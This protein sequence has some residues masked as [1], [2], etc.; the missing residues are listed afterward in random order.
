MTSGYRTGR[1]SFFALAL[2]VAGAIL[3]IDNLGILPRENVR[4]YWPLAFVVAGLG[5]VAN[6]VCTSSLVWAG[7]LS[8][9]GVALILGNLGIIR[10]DASVFWP[11]LLI[12]LG[13][14]SLL[15]RTTF[16]RHWSG[17][18]GGWYRDGRRGPWDCNPGSPAQGRP[19]SSSTQSA[20]A[21]SAGTNEGS[22]PDAESANPWGAPQAWWGKHDWRRWKREERRRRFRDFVEHGY[23]KSAQMGGWL[24]EVAVLFSTRRVFAGRDVSGGKIASV[25]GSIELDFTD[26]NIPLRTRAD[27]TVVR[28]ADIDAD[29]V[30]GS[31]DLRVPPHWRV[32]NRGVGVFGSYENK[33]LPPR[34]EV[35]A[36][37]PTLF[38]HGGAVFGSVE[39]R[40]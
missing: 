39:I 25:F 36:E 11:I 32:I 26:A 23:S 18:N 2:I 21:S 9:F 34:G 5:L 28:L 40:N 20:D 8:V 33:T 30:F 15:R 10:S 19:A 29:A 17:P 6:R 35:G 4:A 31:V 22:I 37:P 7:A 1:G 38:I 13:I 14:L 12:A 27:G 24:H 3:F 16:P